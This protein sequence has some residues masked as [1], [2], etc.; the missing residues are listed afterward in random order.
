[1]Y[2]H[3]CSERAPGPPS[4]VPS[5]LPACPAQLGAVPAT[6]AF[7]AVCA[8]MLH[9]CRC[10]AAAAH[11][12]GQLSYSGVLAVQLGPLA[13]VALDVSMILDC[14]GEP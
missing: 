11:A 7:L 9:S 14:F 2:M 3:P 6:V 4:K 12:T 5:P 1:M 13:A 10:L 8:L